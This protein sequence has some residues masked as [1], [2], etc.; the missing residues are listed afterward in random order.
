[1]FDLRRFP[2]KADNGRSGTR[3]ILQDMK[4]RK[5]WLYPIL[6]LVGGVFG[7]AFSGQFFPRDAEAAARA[8]RVLRAESFVLVDSDGRQRGAFRVDDEGGSAI[9]FYDQDGARRVV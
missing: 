6:A 4:D 7:G 9:V 5:F 3:R 1:M 2:L 8:A